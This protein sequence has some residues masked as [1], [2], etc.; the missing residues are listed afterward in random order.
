MEDARLIATSSIDINFERSLLYFVTVFS[1]MYD[2]YL[3]KHETL[4]VALPALRSQ[5]FQIGRKV[6]SLPEL[7]P[8]L[9]PS[10][11]IFTLG[12]DTGTYL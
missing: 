10:P 3:C 12:E 2:M 8:T 5:T 4:L 1:R 6:S 11:R 7:L 9:Q